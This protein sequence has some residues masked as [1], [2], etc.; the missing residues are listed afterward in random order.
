MG[1]AACDSHPD[2]ETLSA[3]HGRAQ[4][5]SSDAVFGVCQAQGQ[6]TTAPS[7]DR[8][9]K[10]IDCQIRGTHPAVFILGVVYFGW[11]LKDCL[12]S[13]FLRIW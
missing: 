6:G 8:Q 11:S 5:L 3:R 4:A 9:G 2:P 12:T 10:V 13:V 1:K 7:A